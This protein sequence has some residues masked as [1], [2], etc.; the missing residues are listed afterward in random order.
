MC[1]KLARVCWRCFRS[2]FVDSFVFQVICERHCVEKIVQGILDTFLYVNNRNY[3]TYEF[4]YRFG[5]IPLFSLCRNQKQELV[6]A[7]VLIMGNIFL[8]FKKAHTSK[9]YRIQSTFLNG[10]LHV[11]P[12]YYSSVEHSRIDCILQRRPPPLFAW[13]NV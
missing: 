2:C 3:N 6:I 7:G 11:I 12:S 4:S 10:F 1:T 8:Y 9:V 5:F 13:Q